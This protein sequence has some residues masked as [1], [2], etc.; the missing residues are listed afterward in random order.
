MQML[1]R[2]RY[3]CPHRHPNKRKRIV[4]PIRKVKRALVLL[5]HRARIKVAIVRA[6]WDEIAREIRQR[7]GAELIESRRPSFLTPSVRRTIQ[8]GSI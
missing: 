8:Y 1:P 2:L 3:H 7:E 5:I 4:T 6:D